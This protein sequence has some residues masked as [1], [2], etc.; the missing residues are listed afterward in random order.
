ML[1]RELGPGHGWHFLLRA[2]SQR[3]SGPPRLCSAGPHLRVD[4]TQS[5]GSRQF[6]EVV[7]ACRSQFGRRHLPSP[8]PNFVLGPSTPRRLTS[9]GLTSRSLD[10][11]PTSVTGWVGEDPSLS[12]ECFTCNLASYS[13]RHMVPVKVLL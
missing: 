3:L 6:R 5:C 12:P 7:S 13:I 2:F 1:V 8:L 10:S 4:R 11:D 9:L